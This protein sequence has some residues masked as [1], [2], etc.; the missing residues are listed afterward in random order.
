MNAKTNEIF[1]EPKELSNNDIV[2]TGENQSS[3]KDL[4]LTKK[5]RKR[6]KKNEEKQ[7]KSK[8][9]KKRDQRLLNQ[10]NKIL[11]KIKSTEFSFN[12]IDKLFQKS[13]E[14]YEEKVNKVF[15]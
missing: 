5:K 8:V 11:D 1:V 2:Q 3:K 7:I 14:L 4:K 13:R 12:E 9:E 10:K 15:N 6:S